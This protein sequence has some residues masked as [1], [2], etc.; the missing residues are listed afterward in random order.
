MQGICLSETLF[1]LFVLFLNLILFFLYLRQA[2]MDMDWFLKWSLDELQ[3]EDPAEVACLTS[4]VTELQTQLDKVNEAKEKVE[5]S[6]SSL[7]RL[8]EDADST[9]STALDR[10]RVNASKVPSLESAQSKLEVEFYKLTLEQRPDS[11]QRK[12][13]SIR[14]PR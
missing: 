13:L 8:L 10:N 5:A 11:R 3:K 12:S 7:G 6:V 4:K 14:S 2:S 1:D 9:M